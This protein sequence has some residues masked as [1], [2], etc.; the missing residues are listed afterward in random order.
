M[1]SGTQGI[2]AGFGGEGKDRQLTDSR[3]SPREP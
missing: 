3:S 2:R 1:S